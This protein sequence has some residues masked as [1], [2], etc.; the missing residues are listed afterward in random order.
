MVSEGTGT[1]KKL[2]NIKKRHKSQ[3]KVKR[4]QPENFPKFN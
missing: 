3:N 2:L 1:F 4:K